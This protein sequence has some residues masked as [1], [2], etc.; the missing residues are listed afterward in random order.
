MPFFDRGRTKDHGD[1]LAFQELSLRWRNSLDRDQRHPLA[2]GEHFGHLPAHILKE[3]A[4]R[5]QPLVATA[6]LVLTVFFEILEK[7]LAALEGEILDGQPSDPTPG[8]LGNETEKEPQGVSIAPNRSPAEPLL[9]FEI[10]LEEGVHHL[11]QSGG[12]GVPPFSMTGCAKLSNRR[13]AS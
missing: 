9:N 2:G 11:P 4:Q 6:N 7:S 1:F 10:I 5:G 3:G 12:H 8:L 13:L